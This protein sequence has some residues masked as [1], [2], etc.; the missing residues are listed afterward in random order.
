[1]FGFL[2]PDVYVI[3]G[4]MSVS[5]E[6]FFLGGRI[7][8]SMRAKQSEGNV[9]N[10]DKQAESR[11]SRTPRKPETEARV[12]RAKKPTTPGTTR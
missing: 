6:H 3:G 11:A 1:V 7:E 9:P 12:R 4:Y 8:R 2:S 5:A 10:S